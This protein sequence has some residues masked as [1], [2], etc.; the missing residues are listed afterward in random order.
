VLLLSGCAVAP[1]STHTSARTNGEGKSMLTAGSTFGVAK[2]AAVPTVR[3]SLGLSDRFDIGFQ[4]EVVEYGV[5]GKYLL[6][7]GGEGFS[8]SALVGTGL[9]WS[10]FYGFGGGVVSWLSGTFEPYFAERYNYVSFPKNDV[11]VEEVGEVHLDPGTYH[12]LQHSLGFFVWPID[13]LGV[14]IE[15]SAFTTISGPFILKGKDK[16]LF[17]GQASFRF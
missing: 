11:N 2:S 9:G 1:L 10:G 6:A 3:Y 7:G 15:A 14:G 5:S 17:G 16:F 4:Y 12:Y 13:W 8:L